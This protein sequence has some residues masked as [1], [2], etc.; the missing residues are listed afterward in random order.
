MEIAQLKTKVSEL[1]QQINLAE[2]T[3]KNGLDPDPSK[4]IHISSKP[5]PPPT[6][7]APKPKPSKSPLTQGS[8]PKRPKEEPPPVVKFDA[9]PVEP[10]LP[11][12]P[13]SLYHSQL[14]GVV[15]YDPPGGDP[16]EKEKRDFVRR[17]F[18]H[19]FHGYSRLCFGKGSFFFFNVINNFCF[20]LSLIFLGLH[21]SKSLFFIFCE[22]TF[23]LSNLLLFRRG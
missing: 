18:R 15:G 19:A 22:S 10:E 9:D 1:Q 17:V 13:T 3:I 5:K 16:Q 4:V 20:P 8:S 21:S 14:K 23:F 7:K 6:A 12:S 2:Q 11:Y